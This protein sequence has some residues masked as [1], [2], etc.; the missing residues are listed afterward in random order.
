VEDAS[1][2]EG[3]FGSQLQT[4]FLTS[5]CKCPKLLPAKLG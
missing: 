3:D 4:L 5:I 2:D 1:G